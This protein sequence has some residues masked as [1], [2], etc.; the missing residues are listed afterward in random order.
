MAKRSVLIGSVS[1]P[2]FAIQTAE[3]TAQEII[4]LVYV[5]EKI[6]KRKHFGVK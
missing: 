4:S 2:Y 5:F 1:G 3:W 6:I